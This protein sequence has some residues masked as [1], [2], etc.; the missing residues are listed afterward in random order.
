MDRFITVGRTQVPLASIPVPESPGVSADKMRDMLF[1]THTGRLTLA[2][3]AKAAGP[4]IS[5]TGHTIHIHAPGSP[6]PVADTPPEVDTMPEESPEPESPMLDEPLADEM[7]EEIPDEELPP[8]EMESEEPDEALESP[9]EMPDDEEEPLAPNLRL[10]ALTTAGPEP[11]DQEDDMEENHDANYSEQELLRYGCDSRFAAMFAAPAIPKAPAAPKPPPMPKAP[12]LPAAPKIVAP[13]AP[14]VPKA[15]KAPAMPKVAATKAP[16]VPKIAGKGHTINIHPP[17]T[18]SAPSAAP[19]GPP[20]PSPTPPVAA[21]APVPA[22]S[23][24]VSTPKPP[25]AAA[26][27]PGATPPVPAKPPVPAGTP[28]AQPSAA[29]VPTAGQPAAT[30][31]TPG[32]KPSAATKLTPASPLI[33]AHATTKPSRQEALATAGIKVGKNGKVLSGNNSWGDATGG[34]GFVSTGNHAK[35]PAELQTAI[36]ASPTSAPQPKWWNRIG[37][38]LTAANSSGWDPSKLS[39]SQKKTLSDFF[40][41]PNMPMSPA[42]TDAPFP[43]PAD[44][45]QALDKIIGGDFGHGTFLPSL[46]NKG[47]MIGGWFSDARKTDLLNFLNHSAIKRVNFSMVS[48]L[49]TE[50]IRAY[51]MKTNLGRAILR[52][53]EREKRNA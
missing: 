42:A 53:E 33:G 20:A 32:I 11:L 23:P 38:A 1:S 3:F 30:P 40:S 36:Y 37:D 28:A 27:V 17:T 24:P 39:S 43:L 9:E 35:I 34:G 5:G 29:P 8:E 21:P 18:A 6:A 4:H 25:V 49:T 48:E 13:K 45:S 52:A 19:P 51:Q 7:P 22:T 41:D 12:K 31:A 15:P 26:P 2:Y 44:A 10:P 14:P 16:K 46:I 47:G 50:Q